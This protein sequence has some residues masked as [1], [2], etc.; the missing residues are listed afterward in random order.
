MK[1]KNVTY[2]D[3]M[4]IRVNSKKINNIIKNYKENIGT[5][6]Y[7]LPINAN[8]DC[9]FINGFFEITI[10]EYKD[11]IDYIHYINEVKFYNC[12]GELGNYLKF[13]IEEVCNER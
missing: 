9:N 1:Y 5:T 10:D 12:I 3:K 2:K 8:P 4:L 6:I 11:Y 13:Y 7:I